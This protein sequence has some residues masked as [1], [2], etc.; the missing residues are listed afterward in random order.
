MIYKDRIKVLKET[1]IDNSLIN[2]LII[3]SHSPGFHSSVMDHAKA[4]PGNTFGLSR[5]PVYLCVTVIL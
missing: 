4:D 1:F 5:I 2:R 3:N